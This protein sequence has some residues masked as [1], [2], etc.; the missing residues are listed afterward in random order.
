VNRSAPFRWFRRPNSAVPTKENEDSGAH[1]LPRR[2]RTCD[3]TVMSGRISISFVDFTAFSFDF[4]WVRCA[5]PRRFLVRNRC[6][7]GGSEGPLDWASSQTLSR[8]FISN[9]RGSHGQRTRSR[10]SLRRELVAVAEVA[11]KVEGNT[12]ICAKGEQILGRRGRRPDHAR[13]EIMGT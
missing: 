6:G 13:A 12:G 9:V 11:S 1:N 8:V 7:D 10:L 4:G 5:L 3:Q 2:I